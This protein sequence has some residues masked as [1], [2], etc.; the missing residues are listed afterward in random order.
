MTFSV[1]L[2]DALAKATLAARRRVASSGF[3]SSLSNQDST[4]WGPAAEPEASILLG[5]TVHPGV[6]STVASEVMELRSE[7]V[8]EGITRVVLCGMGGSSLGPEVMAASDSLPL[9]VV[10][11]THPHEIGPELARDLSDTVIVVSSKSGG[12]L[13][14]DS[15]R[16]AF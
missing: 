6:W 12:T 10:D 16:R 4:L 5:W 8:A 7:L 1:D 11:S 9:T 14:T 13:E 2:S 3:M 15:Q